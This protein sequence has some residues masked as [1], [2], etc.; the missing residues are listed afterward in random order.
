MFR[1][2]PSR[3]WFQKIGII[4]DNNTALLSYLCHHFLLTYSHPYFGI[5]NPQT[6]ALLQE[7]LV[8]THDIQWYNADELPKA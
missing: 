2:L 4:P 6:T 8:A 3:S 7:A 5:L 1:D